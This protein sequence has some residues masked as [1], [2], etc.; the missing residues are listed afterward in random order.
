MIKIKTNKTFPK[1]SR[2]KIR[3]LKN[4]DKIEEYNI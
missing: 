1:G 2:Q 4:E 3:N